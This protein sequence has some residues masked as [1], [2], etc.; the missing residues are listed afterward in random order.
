MH[1]DIYEENIHLQ[2]TKPH[3]QDNSDINGNWRIP[4]INNDI[5]YI[6]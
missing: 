3:V 4:I 2:E 5:L 1:W 6:V